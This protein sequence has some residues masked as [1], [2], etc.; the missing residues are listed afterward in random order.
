MVAY[1][2]QKTFVPAI[3]AGVKRQTIRAD[4]RRHARPG[5]S[6][7]LYSGMR[8]RQC[9]K[10][11]DDPV[12]ERL[13]EIRIDLRSLAGTEPAGEDNAAMM[14]QLRAVS[15]EINGRALNRGEKHLLAMA[16][17]FST[18]EFRKSKLPMLPFVAM[19]TFW[20]SEHGSVDFRGVI[21][22]WRPQ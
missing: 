20:M 17:G 12:C 7:Q 14:E 10:I 19:V 13:D 11:I 18:W 15:I 16:D 4:R 8:T 3:R 2:F 6:M 5:E 1:S 22:R 9:F 21:I